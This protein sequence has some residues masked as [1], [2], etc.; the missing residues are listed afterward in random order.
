MNLLLIAM[1]LPVTDARG[2]GDVILPGYELSYV[3][4]S[5]NMVETVDTDVPKSCIYSNIPLVKRLSSENPT[6]LND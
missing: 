4:I 2:A 6:L 3:L 5:S 1:F